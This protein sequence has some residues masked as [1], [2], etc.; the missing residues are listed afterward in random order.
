MALLEV[1]NLTKYFG[2]LMAAGDVSFDIEEGQIFTIIGPNGA[3]KTTTFNMIAGLYGAT[4]GS[5]KFQGK[6]LLGMTADQ[7]AHEGITRTFQI[8]SLFFGISVYENILAGMH[9]KQTSGILDTLFMTKKYREE[10]AMIRKRA[11][12]VLEFVGLAENKDNEADS[13]PYGKQRLLEIAIAYASNPKLILLDE[14]AAGLN[15]E[16][17]KQLVDLIRRIRDSGVT[18]LLIEHNMGLVMN[19]SDEIMVLDHGVTIAQGLPHDIANNPKVIEAYL[20]RG[21]AE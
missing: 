9:T 3:G 6:E 11:D 13:L 20:G 17:T 10:E 14:P 4:S 8:T 1:R 7:I 12:E 18:V 2:G 5:V 16:E 21:E 15:P 19:I